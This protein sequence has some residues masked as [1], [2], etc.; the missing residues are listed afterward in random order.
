LKPHSVFFA[1]I[2]DPPPYSHIRGSRHKS[3]KK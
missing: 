2:L 1:A 3:K